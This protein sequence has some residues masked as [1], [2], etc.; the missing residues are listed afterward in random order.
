[1]DLYLEDGLCFFFRMGLAIFKD[2]KWKLKA[3]NLGNANLWWSQLSDWTFSPDFEADQGMAHILQDYR[4]RVKRR[5]AERIVAA[6]LTDPID[7]ELL[8]KEDIT[9]LRLMPTTS[10]TTTGPIE[11]I[12]NKRSYLKLLASFLPHSQRHRSLSCCYSSDRHG[13]SLETL[14]RLCKKVHPCFL[15][16]EEANHG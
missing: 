10:S 16:I 12:L 11:C 9:P 15:I 3:L 8:I 5:N 1:M 7:Q 4:H 6:R 13:R 14:Y 2:M